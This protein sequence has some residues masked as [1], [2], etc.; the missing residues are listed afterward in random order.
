ML[1]NILSKLGHAFLFDA[2]VCREMFIPLVFKIPNHLNKRTARERTR[3]LEFP[4]AL[5]ATEALKT[6]GL[7]PHWL[8]W[9]GD[10]LI[11]HVQN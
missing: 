9:H 7:D 8:P 5:G 4:I 1:R 2:G 6:R 10:I 11:Q 3:R